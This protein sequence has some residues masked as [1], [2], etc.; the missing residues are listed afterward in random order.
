MAEALV[1]KRR[2]HAFLS[3]AHVDK[4]QADT[5][6]HLL[7]DVANIPVWYDSVN[8]PPGATIA[9]NLFEAI[10]NSRAVIILLSRQSIAGAGFS[11]KS[12]R[13]SISRRD[14]RTS[15]SSHF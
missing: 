2:F 9:D 10:Q 13:L 4:D 6:F 5:L 8:L 14:I 3:H 12:G 11:R 1:G 7:S 15:E